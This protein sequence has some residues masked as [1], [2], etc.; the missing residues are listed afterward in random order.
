MFLVALKII[1][2]DK[3]RSLITLIGVV[4]A[5]ALIFAQIGI[6]LGLMETSSIII[7][8][9]P[10][11]IWITS[12]NSR[13]FDFSQPFPEY[14]I[15]KVLATEG[16]KDAKKLIVVWGVI[17]QEEGGTEQV[18]VVGYNPDTGIGGPWKMRM[19]HFKDVKNGNYAIID[20]SSIRRL[21]EFKIG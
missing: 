11:D 21:G 4:F 16:I 18:E 20:E 7:D 8:H 5:V 15:N 1:L 17:K 14:K 19:G 10:G 9:T 2:Y 6:Y 13:N 12:K 3:V